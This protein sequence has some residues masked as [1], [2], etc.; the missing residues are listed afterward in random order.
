MWV[1]RWGMATLFGRW[2][3]GPASRHCTIVTLHPN[4]SGQPKPC[5][6]R[7]HP[8]SQSCQLL[9]TTPRRALRHYL[10]A[11]PLTRQALAHVEHGRHLQCAA[12]ALRPHKLLKRLEQRRVVLGLR[13]AA[14]CVWEGM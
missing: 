11:L 9:D 4:N 8:P 10:R 6:P 1:C 13:A 7:G 12:V 14:V 2:A 3:C 5:P